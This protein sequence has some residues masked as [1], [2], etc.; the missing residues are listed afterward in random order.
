MFG[1]F[2]NYAQLH[3][4]RIKSILSTMWVWLRLSGPGLSMIF[5]KPAGSKCTLKIHVEAHPMVIRG[6][7]MMCFSYVKLFP[8][9]T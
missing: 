8:G 3:C 7:F 4:L 2:S 9:K 5:R 1:N 6:S